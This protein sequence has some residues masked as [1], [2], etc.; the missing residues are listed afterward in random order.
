[1]LLYWIWFSQLSGIPLWKKRELLQHFSDPE[2]LYYTDAQELSAIE[3]MTDEILEALSQKDVQEAEKILALC[4]R[5]DIGLLPYGDWAY[6]RRLKGISD[7]PMV[8]YYRGILPDWDARPFVAVVGTRKATAYGLQVAYQLGSQISEC[9]GM[10]ISGGAG[11]IDS[12][13]M[14]GALDTDTPVVGVLGCGVDEIYP[15][16]NRRLF[17]RVVRSGCLISEYPPGE[18]PLGWHFPRRNRII[19]GISHGVVVVEAPEKSGALNTAHHAMEQGRDIYA[20]PANIGLASGA[21]SNGLLQQ[22]AQTVL[23]GWD[24]VKSYEPLFPDVLHRTEGIL[25]PGRENSQPKVA[26]KPVIPEKVQKKAI[27]NL[28]KSSYS[29]LDNREPALSSEEQAI[30]ALLSRNPEHSDTVAEKSSMPAS[31]VQSILTKLTLKGLV[32]HH[33]GG[34]V[35]LKL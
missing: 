21:G 35:S 9:G 14:E 33:S 30:L 26:E 29:V 17:S 5:K 15:R 10:V 32:M 27:D 24:A 20:V 19:S 8:L 23:N 12:K 11:G 18:P 31:K 3:G 28:D 2:E 34:R 13:A 16:T 25:C 22:G 6:P 1:M 4:K 7:P